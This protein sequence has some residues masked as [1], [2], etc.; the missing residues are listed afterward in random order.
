MQFA[1]EPD[2]A[3]AD[4]DFD[5]ILQD[6]LQQGKGDSESQLST[7]DHQAAA[8]LAKRL[9]DRVLKARGNQSESDDSD[10]AEPA[11]MQ[12]LIE[13]REAMVSGA[14]QTQPVSKE[15]VDPEPKPEPEPET[16]PKAERST[17]I[18]D[19]DKPVDREEVIQPTGAD[20]GAAVEDVELSPFAKALAE[21]QAATPATEAE[22]LWAEDDAIEE[23]EA[24]ADDTPPE[25]TIT[26]GKT[27]R[28]KNAKAA[29]KKKK[30]GKP[31]RRFFGKTTSGDPSAFDDTA[32]DDAASDDASDDP[33]AWA[34][35]E[36]PPAAEIDDQDPFLKRLL[37]DIPLES[38]KDTDGDDDLDDKEPPMTAFGSG[39]GTGMS[40]VAPPRLVSTRTPETARFQ[41]IAEVI[42]PLAMWL[43]MAM[44]IASLVY[45]AWAGGVDVIVAS[46]FGGGLLTFGTILILAGAA[47]AYSPILLT[48]FLWKRLRKNKANA[49]VLAGSEILNT[50][51]LAEA[52]IDADAD[53]RL[54]TTPDGVVVYAND[55]YLRVAEEAGIKGST[56]LPPRID[57]LFGQS[58]TESSK[59]FRLAK[60][61]RSGAAAEEVLTQTMGSAAQAAQ[62]ELPLRRFN[63]FVR[64]MRPAGD[65]EV[66]A[67]W[68]LH[69]MPVDRRQDSLKS[70]YF[71]LPRAVVALE[72]S[73]A[74]AWMNVKAAELF[75]TKP[76]HTLALGDVI[77]GEVKPIVSHLWEPD[78]EEYEARIRDRSP[79]RPGTSRDVILTPFTK[80]G[81]GEGFVC[82]EVTEKGAQTSDATGV[83]A[84]ADLTEAPFGVAVLEGDPSTDG[85]ITYANNLF[86]SYFPEASEGA[87]FSTVLSATAI[88]ELSAAMRARQSQK[89]LTKPIEIRVG[90]G[91]Q[92]HIFRVYARPVRRRRGAYGPR[93]TVLYAVDITYQRRMEEDSVQGQKL[94]QIGQIAGS[95]AH[96]F[97]NLLV[98]VMGSTELLMR[99]HPVGDPSYRDLAMIYE[100]AQRAQNLTRNLL[101]FSRKQTLKPEVCSLTELLNDFT[102]ALKRYVSEKVSLD[103]VH[104][105]SIPQV[106]A[107][108]GQ[109]H[110]AVMN[111][112]VN[113]RDAMPGGG[114]LRIETKHISADEIADYG[115][116]V[117]E[118]VDHV[119][120]E[121]ADTGGGVPSEH[122]DH[123]F[124][125]FYT[126]KGEGQGTGLGLST[127]SGA[128][129]QMGGRIFLYNRPEEGATFRIFLPA[130]SQEEADAAAERNVVNTVKNDEAADPTG[131]GRILVVEDE[132]G[133]RSIVVRALTM[134][135]YEIVEASDGDEALEIL[136]EDKERFDLVLTD[137]MMPEMDGPTLIE[138]AGEKLRGAQ[139]VFM[140]GYAEAAMRDK[141]NTIEGARYLQKPFTL[142]TVAAVVKEALTR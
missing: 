97:N 68:R 127:V 57:R 8:D 96:D 54:V 100:T 73:G 102:P 16:D 5:A 70:A 139:V 92:A 131:K 63:V 17:P 103:V 91:A 69:E 25:P 118:E 85:R 61:C 34:P 39:G 65:G 95:V 112:A 138:E 45:G 50:L 11:D 75:G 94:Q 117:L 51:G 81:P 46:L 49:A 126:T 82:V 36:T 116:E 107:D 109:I 52:I 31:K 80:G 99:N 141:L 115:Y 28:N 20:D 137:I 114:S 1:P 33:N 22:D 37:A 7:K 83:Q 130:V 77:M 19:Q 40:F 140:S 53:A 124:E 122:A 79:D 106:K 64:P 120:V 142:T 74:I 12:K 123:I 3:E 101:A 72:R 42:T 125:P 18:A 38:R 113:A 13:A 43:S 134:C 110:L 23:A 121:V 108:K 6:V 98:V 78:A 62:G 128:I 84:G 30:P 105:R 48:S 55:A 14:A 32:P 59:M 86:G 2:E 27:K 87:R 93:Q 29:G 35:D 66:Y 21:V 10:L 56:G 76:G 136:E 15:V 135:G 4:R 88:N 58:G 24:P 71:N 133:V 47:K 111:L 44:V 41:K 104:G 26:Q 89:P 90:E 60:A 129:A 9:A 67:A 119:L 132:D